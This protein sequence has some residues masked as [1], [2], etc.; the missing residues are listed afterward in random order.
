LCLRELT[1]WDQIKLKDFGPYPTFDLREVVMIE[2]I[3]EITIS[4]LTII[5]MWLAG[6]KSKNAPVMGLIA[7]AGWFIWIIAYQHW[8]LLVLNICLIGMYF[9]MYNKWRQ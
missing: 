5:T 4:I 3:A 8:G 9:R 1:L 6:D 7:E 2:T